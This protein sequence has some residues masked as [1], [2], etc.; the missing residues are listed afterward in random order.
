[1]P[2][3]RRFSTQAKKAL[4][5]G[6]KR[7][8]TVNHEQATQAATWFF[9]VSREANKSVATIALHH[10]DRRPTCAW[11]Q[12]GKLDVVQEWH[13]PIHGTFGVTLKCDAPECAKFTNV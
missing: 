3:V 13:N 4:W 12:R 10:A 5:V 8:E 7:T 1:M 11:C 6:L 2:R 9:E